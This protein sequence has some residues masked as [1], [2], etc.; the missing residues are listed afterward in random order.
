MDLETRAVWPV[1][2]EIRQEGQRPVI[3]GRFPYGEMATIGDRGTVRKEMFAPRA[4]EYA[5]NDPTR[6]INFLYGH[7][8]N[9]PLASRKAGTFTLEDRADSVAFEAV[10]PPESEQPTWVRDFLYARRAGLVGGISPG[11]RVPP[12]TAVSAAET[13]DQEPG[14]PGVM[15]RTIRAAVLG[16]FSAVTRPAY[17]GT[18]I[19]ERADGL[20]VPA[21]DL[22]LYRW[23]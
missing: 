16:E 4:F 18:E 14:N 15:I 10:L 17:L 20:A 11:F 3:T 2:L 7:S 21:R 19:E 22:E 9:R 5:I 13:L 8:F 12:R 6:E 1:D 23:L